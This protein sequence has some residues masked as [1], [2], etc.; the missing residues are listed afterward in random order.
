MNPVLSTGPDIDAVRAHFPAL[1]GETV[2]LENAGGSQM[3]RLVADRMHE[4]MLNTFVQLEAG[5]T[6]ADR[7]D[8]VIEDAHAFV[9]R[10]VNGSATGKVILGPSCSQLVRNLADAYGDVLEPG[11]EVIITDMGHEANV[12]PW[13]K[14]QERGIVVKTWPVDPA[15][16]E[17]HEDVLRGLLTD[18]TRVVAFVHVSNLLGQILDVPAITTLAHDAGARVV[19]DGV[20]YAPHRAIDVQ[21]WNV[22]WY[23]FSIYKVYGPHM[24]ALYGRHDAL[25]ELTGPNHFFIPREEIP[26]KFE[27]GGVNH[28]GCA[29][30]LGLQEYLRALAE[31]ATGEAAAPGPLPHETIAA[32]FGAMEALE[33]PLQVRLLSYLAAK[34]GVR[35]VGPAEPGP[36]RVGTI[37]FVHETRSCQEICK[38]AHAREIGIRNGHMYAYRLCEAMDIEPEDG[39]VRVS[40]VHYNT[41]EE[42]DKLIEVLETVL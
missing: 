14:L 3:P 33:H 22:D 35:I 18:R 41:V 2:Y 36:D 26:Y 21:A 25:A 4:Y 1:A 6:I 8:A 10:L 5:Y 31:L 24:A 42:I 19:V 38:A 16:G 39:V 27:L 15:T 37:S 30:L 40:F 29:A 9:E 17:N 12:G 28:E 13:V 7:C 11:D 34:P 32:A 23:A 20:A